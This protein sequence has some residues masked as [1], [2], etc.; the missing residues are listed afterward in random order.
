MIK[1]IDSGYILKDLNEKLPEEKDFDPWNGFL[2]AQCAWKNFGGLNL[3]EAFEKFCD[4]PLKYQED[5]MFMGPK[6]FAYYYPVLDKYLREV[7]PDD[8]DD[9]CEAWGIVCAFEMQ[10]IEG[11]NYFSKK[12]IDKISEI[13]DVAINRFSKYFK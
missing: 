10:L 1:L 6:A 7:Q 3:C 9:D 12:L 13:H 4:N 5:F 11:K 8:E 2:D